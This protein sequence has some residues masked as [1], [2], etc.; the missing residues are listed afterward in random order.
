[1]ILYVIL[2][3]GGNDNSPDSLNAMVNYQYHI[4]NRLIAW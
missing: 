1:M 4:E 2:K 3:N